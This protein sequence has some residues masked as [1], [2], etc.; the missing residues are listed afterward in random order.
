MFISKKLSILHV[1]LR[2]L[3]GDDMLEKWI[4]IPSHHL[5]LTPP[6]CR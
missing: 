5:H 2:V 3:Y 4:N 1:S 6:I